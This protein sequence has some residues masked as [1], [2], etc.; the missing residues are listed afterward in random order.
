MYMSKIL[1]FNPTLAFGHFG[2][3]G[4]GA[5]LVLLVALAVVVV[6]VLSKPSTPQ[7]K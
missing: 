5:G 3:R 6:L 1:C 4:A 2:G 7:G